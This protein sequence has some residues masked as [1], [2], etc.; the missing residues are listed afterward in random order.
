[1]DR[2]KVPMHHDLKAAYFQALRAAIFMMDAGDM[3]RVKRV[4]EKRGRK[5]EQLM[6][7]NFRYI[8]LRV[9][10]RIPPANILYHRVKA[11]FDF[12]GDKKDAETQ[13]PLFNEAATKKA[14]L[15]LEMIRL[16]YL[17]DPPNAQFYTRKTNIHGQPMVDKDGLWLFRSFRGTPLTESMHQNLS[18][19]FGHTR[20]G[21]RYSDNLLARVRHGFNWRASERN[22]PHFPQVGHYNGR[23]LDTINQ[24]YETLFEV[25]KYPHWQH[26][27]ETT[28]QKLLYGIVPLD[29][30]ENENDSVKPVV[31]RKRRRPKTCKVPGCPAPVR[32]P[33]SYMRENCVLNT[34]GDPAKKVKR[35][36]HQP[37]K[38]HAACKVPDCPS[39]HSRNRCPHKS[40]C[41]N[42]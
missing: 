16:G 9:K 14:K 11:V 36:K 3:A 13:K 33:G 31:A 37:F 41:I 6:A 42:R 34:G 19:S 10:R 26:F 4:V 25:P 29:E 40:K 22:R 12:F 21:P 38:R 8:A 15:V 28:K 23:A 27:N 7:F 35:K 18:T 30:G 20:A 24:L 32:C 5:W 1:M 39:H 2:V 17:S